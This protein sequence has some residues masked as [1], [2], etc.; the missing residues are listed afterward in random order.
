[1]KLDINM[2]KL[3]KVIK[4]TEFEQMKT[5]EQKETFT[6]AMIDEKTGKRKIFFN[7]GPKND[8]RT[9]LDNK[10]KE[11]IEIADILRFW[12]IGLKHKLNI[13]NI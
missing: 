8:W 13:K 7:L 2:I 3:N 12:L 10:N 1:M 4:T 9:N 11:K 5:K 6:E